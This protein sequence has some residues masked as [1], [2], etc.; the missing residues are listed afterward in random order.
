MCVRGHSDV[1][2]PTRYAAGF[3]DCGTVNSGIPYRVHSSGGVH[4]FWF[5][6]CQSA[7][8]IHIYI[9]LSRYKTVNARLMAL[10]ESTDVLVQKAVDGRTVPSHGYKLF[11]LCSAFN[12]QD[13]NFLVSLSTAAVT[14]HCRIGNLHPPGIQ[15]S[16]SLCSSA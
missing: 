10:L 8:L 16:I 1:F 15:I 2:S 5:I 7:C 13:V 9:L 4:V 6:L 3:V 12:I 11:C 14:G